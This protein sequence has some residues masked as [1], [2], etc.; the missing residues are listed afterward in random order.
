MSAVTY[1]E[2]MEIFL[3]APSDGS[4]LRVH[5]CTAHTIVE[6]ADR[7]DLREA[8]RSGGLVV[9]DGVPLVWVGRAQGRKMGRVCGLDVLPDLCDRGRAQGARHYFYGG[10]EGVAQQ[11]ADHLSRLYPGLLVVG[12]E[13]P[14][15]RPLAAEERDAVINR[16]NE[17]RPDYIWVGLGTPK[18]DLWLA[19]Y[20][21]P[22]D[23]AAIMAVGAAFDIVGG[24]RPRAPY[25]MQRLGLE[26]LFRL[27]QEPR[28][29]AVRYS[30]VNARFVGIVLVA[31][32]SGRHLRGRR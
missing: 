4:R 25:T 2:A 20:R 7:P 3:A 24:F 31:A 14:P 19:E 28:R 15:F 27:I 6:A 18:Q 9:P 29:L 1:E 30:L 10:G 23:A 32:A 22:L 11:L 26:W 5:F 21:E 8:L 13:T 16:L 12:A 17:A